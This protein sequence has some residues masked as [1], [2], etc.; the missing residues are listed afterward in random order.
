M[1]III[2][3][4]GNQERWFERYDAPFIAKHLL[5]VRKQPLLKRTIDL[6]SPY[7]DVTVFAWDWYTSHINYPCY[8]ISPVKSLLD[9]ILQTRD[10]WGDKTVFLLGDVLFS[11][12]S[13][14]DIVEIDK[15]KFFG[16]P[17]PNP[18]SGKNAGELFGFTMMKDDWEQVIEYCE[19]MTT[20]KNLKHSPKLWALYRLC[21]GNECHQEIIDLELLEVI[22]DYTDDIDSSQAYNQFWDSMTRAEL[23]DN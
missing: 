1:N 11:R 20:T 13:A 4:H 2:M 12:Q 3:A 17:G 16:R 8:A 7:G 18:V 21:C 10:S 14:L 6:F 15:L 19:F 23:A 22:N 5:P 9:G